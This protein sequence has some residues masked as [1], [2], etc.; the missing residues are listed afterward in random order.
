MCEDLPAKV[1]ET[2]FRKIKVGKSTEEMHSENL[3]SLLFH[4]YL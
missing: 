3:I 4:K 2:V 1:R